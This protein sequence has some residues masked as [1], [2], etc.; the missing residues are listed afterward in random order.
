MQFGFKKKLGTRHALYVLQSTVQYFVKNG[1]TVNVAL[2]DISKAFDNVHHTQ[3]FQKLLDLGLPP[4]IVELLAVWYGGS[5]ACV[6]WRMCMSTCFSLAVGVTCK[7]WWC[8][9]PSI[10]HRV[11][12]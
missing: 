1:S 10:V 6:R 5:Y 9:V 8:T 2:L 7:T 4:G 3:L 11:C 12:K